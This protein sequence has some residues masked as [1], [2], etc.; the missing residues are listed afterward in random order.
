MKFTTFLWIA[1]VT[2]SGC[3]LAAG[4]RSYSINIKPEHARGFLERHIALDQ[5]QGS[6]Q[7]VLIRKG[8]VLWRYD[9]ETDETLDLS[10]SSSA[11]VPT[12][13]APLVDV[14]FAAAFLGTPGYLTLQN[15]K[16]MTQGKDKPTIAAVILG[17]VSGFY[18][19]HKAGEWWAERTVL[20]SFQEYLKPEDILRLEHALFRVHR[21]RIEASPTPPNLPY[22][23]NP[24]DCQKAKRRLIAIAMTPSTPLNGSDFWQ[25]AI[26][27]ACRLLPPSVAEA[28][29][30]AKSAL[31]TKTLGSNVGVRLADGRV[32]R[33]LP[34]SVVV[35][36][37]QRSVTLPPGVG[38]GA[39]VPSTNP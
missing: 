21:G 7:L 25:P 32:V 15:F 22:L 39:P 36:T 18:A 24:E 3:A 23:P 20:N 33:I 4:L 10:L 38:L 6:P 31:G 16:S 5:T 30:P 19:G 26:E 12:P 11:M 28:P 35:P 27:R 2:F 13:P 8:E 17:G 9:I 1:L 14:A 37:A 29:T 34:H